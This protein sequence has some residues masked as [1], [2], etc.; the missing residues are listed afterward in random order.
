MAKLQMSRP[1]PAKDVKRPP[2]TPEITRTIAFH[3]E[4]LGIFLN[5][6]RFVSRLMK[7]R[8]EAKDAQMLT[9]P[10]FFCPA[11]NSG[12]TSCKPSIKPVDYIL[13]ILLINN[14]QCDTH[15]N[16]F[17]NDCIFK[18]NVNVPDQFL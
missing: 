1:L 9:N 5:V 15:E 6:R 8:T 11:D 13:V 17:F 3:M 12:S 18:K 4:N 2:K 14:I 16:M 10:I 7:T